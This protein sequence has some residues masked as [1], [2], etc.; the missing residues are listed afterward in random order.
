VNNNA[1]KDRLEVMP[2]YFWMYNLYALQRNSW[3][4]A[5]R[6][7]RK[8]KVQRIEMDY[9]A[10]DTAEEIMSALELMEG[11]MRDAG[12]ALPSASVAGSALSADT[13]GEEDP[14]YAYIP[15]SDDEI[16]AYGL[17]RHNRTT[18]ILKPRRAWLAYREMLRFYGMKTLIARLEERPDLDFPGLASE[19]AA[20][21][22]AWDEAA[23]NGR[24]RGWVNLGGQI[25]PSFRVD[26]LRREIGEGRIGSWSSIH[27]GYSVMAAAY[28]AD[29][30]RHA[31][32]IL[33]Y[34]WGEE[35]A[36]KPH[37]ARDRE[38]FKAE[39]RAALEIQKKVTEEVYRSRA[40]DFHD[41]F[42]GI[43]YRSGEEMEAVAGKAE[44]NPFV[45]LNREKLKQFEAAAAAI[46]DRL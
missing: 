39:I 33:R 27:N 11:W 25:A 36:G 23:E 22:P 46:L 12:V 41:P 16:P 15:H 32:S 6:D 18:A 31:W 19:I 20:P 45:R 1:Q 8:H 37:P 3:K 29:R 38:A 2:A 4:A 7:K 5:D 9:L 30:L 43:T 24:V 35:E 42:R 28:P 40:K 26:A 17:E 34:L 44:Q 10:P 13:P 14:E 21:D